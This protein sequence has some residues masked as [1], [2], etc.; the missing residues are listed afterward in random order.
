MKGIL[1]KVKIWLMGRKEH[2]TFRLQE[3]VG[4]GL[5]FRV[6]VGKSGYNMQ[7]LD[8]TWREYV[9]SSILIMFQM[10]TPHKSISLLL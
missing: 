9:Y 10:I 5:A 1:R 4:H 2:V 8:V 7:K 3:V 6:C